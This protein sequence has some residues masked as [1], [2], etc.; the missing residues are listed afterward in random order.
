MYT[1]FIGRQLSMTKEE[2]RGLYRAF[3]SS[4][5]SLGNI[6]V[7]AEKLLD[8]QLELSKQLGVVNILSEEQLA[9][10][11]KLKEFADLEEGSRAAIAQSSI[12]TGKSSEATVKAIIGQVAG[13]KN[14]TGIAFQYQAIISEAANLGGYLGLQFAKYP[15]QLTNSLLITKALGTSL[16]EMDSIASS[17]LDFESSISKE[18]EAQILTGKDLNLNRARALFLENDLAGAAQ[19][20]NRQLGSSDDFLKL[21]RIQAESVAEAFGM[22]RDSMAQMLK[23]QEML[24]KLGAK[25]TD[26]ATKRLDLARMR[27]GEEVK[28]NEALGEGA[29]QQLVTAS[30]QEKLALGIEKI[31][32]S[33][34][35][36]RKPLT[37]CFK[38]DFGFE[39][40]AEFPAGSFHDDCWF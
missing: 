16:K 10:N 5:T 31:K 30:T 12:I 6:Y 23:T 20:I 1:G 37:E 14:A 13:L 38:D 28:I 19:E 15:G 7:T 27:F 9:T 34:V 33:L 26:S 39:F 35:E 18:F 8:S 32:Q 11:I 40:G 24:V 4:E 29:Y 25:D 22:S 36:L 17:F 3:S 2:A 21:N